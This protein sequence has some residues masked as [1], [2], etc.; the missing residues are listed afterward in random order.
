MIVSHW[1]ILRYQN[2]IM[3]FVLL[4]NELSVKTTVKGAMS[5][6]AGA[7]GKLVQITK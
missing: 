4:T 3:L 7:V 2:V 5:E 6:R 1:N